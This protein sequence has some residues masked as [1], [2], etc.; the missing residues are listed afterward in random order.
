VHALLRHLEEVGF[1]GAPRL[2][3]VDEDAGVEVLSFFPGAAGLAPPLD[4]AVQTDESLVAAARLIRRF[5]DAAAGFRPAPDACWQF[6]EEAPRTGPL[7][8][9][10]D[11]AAYNLVYQDGIPH[12]IIDWDFAAPATP[13]WDLAHAAWYLVPLHT[14]EYDVQ[15]GWGRVDIPRRLRLFVDAYG[16]EDRSGF[17]ELIA[18]RQVSTFV[19]MDR[20]AAAGVPGFQ[21]LVA[22]GPEITERPD[23]DLLARNLDTWQ[24]AL[25]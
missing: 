2:L 22:D 18:R 11:L 6:M 15:V 19:T 4:P 3:D 23:L 9:H 21:E 25:D 13:A 24:R 16:L 1:D 5:H 12:G 8:C 17:V 20:W 7:V 10:N 14:P